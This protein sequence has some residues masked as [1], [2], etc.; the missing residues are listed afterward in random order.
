MPA[1]NYH[2]RN[3]VTGLDFKG[4]VY[5]KSLGDAQVAAQAK[6]RLFGRSTKLIS[7]ERVRVEPP[8]EAKPRNNGKADRLL[9]KKQAKKHK[10]RR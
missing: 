4:Y 10:R 2:I 7:V 3:K 9:A 6:V 8:V 1:Y 5:E